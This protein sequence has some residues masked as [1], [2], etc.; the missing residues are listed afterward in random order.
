VE[1]VVLGSEKEAPWLRRRRI[2]WAAARSH[3]IALLEEYGIA[4][5]GPG[6]KAGSLSGGNQQKLVVARELSRNP[7]VLVAEN[8]TRGLDVSAAAQIHNRIRR[9]AAQA[10]A[11]L[12]YSSDLDEVL[13]LADRIVV[14]ARGSLR[15]V[16]PGASREAVGALMLSSDRQP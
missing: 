6:A 1:N 7:R 2:Q 9:T 5:A 12:F 4:A 15:E 8:P 10:A 14:V 11:V 16:P 13:S 3:T